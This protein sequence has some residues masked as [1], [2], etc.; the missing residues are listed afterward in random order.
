MKLYIGNLSYDLSEAELR[1]ALAEFEP[2]LDVHLPKDR[3]TGQPRGFAFVTLMNR[4]AGEAAIQALDGHELAGRRLRV[5]EAEDR[6]GG[7]TS[8]RGGGGDDNHFSRPHAPKRKD[9]R[10]VDSEGKRVRYKGI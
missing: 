5:N 7:P 6:G 2:I 10:P 1:E 3:E 8:H 4:E 9:D